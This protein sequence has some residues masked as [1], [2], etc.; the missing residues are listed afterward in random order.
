MP[1]LTGSLVVSGAI[2]RADILEIVAPLAAHYRLRFVEYPWFWE[3]P[4]DRAVYS[5][6]GTVVTWSEAVSAQR[7]LERERPSAVVLFYNTAYNQVALRIAARERGIPVIHLEHG[8]RLRAGVSQAARLMDREARE[9]WRVRRVAKRLESARN[10]AFLARS[11]ADGGRRERTELASYLQHTFVRGV[12]S[13]SLRSTTEIRRCDVYVSF[14]P[15][16]FEYHR[17]MDAIPA[18]HSVEY[19]GFPQFDAYLDKSSQTESDLVLLVDHQ[20]HNSGMFGWTAEFRRSWAERLARLV[21]AAGRS[22]VVKTHPGDQSGVWE[23]FVRNGEVRLLSHGELPALTDRIGLVLGTF[24]TLQVPLAAMR[25]VALLA[26]EIHPETGAF[27][28]KVFVDAGVAEPIFTWDELERALRDVDGVRAR[29]QPHKSA[30]TRQFV[31]A[32]DGH[33]AE[34][35]VAAVERVVR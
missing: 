7:F 24:S 8:F 19:V 30:Y 23:P 34:R 14:S 25:H 21:K 6:L 15:E 2:G 1:S 17:E 10:Y 13:A 11:L 5:P 12:D 26:L 22:L 31:H 18:G 28:S 27:P 29:Q 20:F 32:L 16:C 4:L 35:L 3:R 9:R 33:A